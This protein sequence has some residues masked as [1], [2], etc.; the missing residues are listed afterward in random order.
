MKGLGLLQKVIPDKV[1]PSYVHSE[2]SFAQL[3]GLEGKDKT[4]CAFDDKETHIAV[5]SA[6]GTYTF[7]QFSSG[8]EAVRVHVGTVL[9]EGL[10]GEAFEESVANTH[11][12]DVPDSVWRHPDAAAANR[13]EAGQSEAV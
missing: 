7:A 1:M 12:T 10:E 5:I 11:R 13:G 3:R 4:Y 6:D 9:G 8:G 2:W